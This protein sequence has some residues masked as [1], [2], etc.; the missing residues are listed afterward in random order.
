MS[1]SSNNPNFNAG[2]ASNFLNQQYA[3]QVA[4]SGDPVGKVRYLKT[5]LQLPNISAVQQSRIYQLINEAEHQILNQQQQQRQQQQQQQQQRQPQ[6]QQSQQYMQQQQSRQ[7]QSRQQQSRQQSNNMSQ[8]PMATTS[9]N[10]TQPNIHQM[11]IGMTGSGERNI[12]DHGISTGG[13][14]QMHIPIRGS[15]LSPHQPLE[16][17]NGAPGPASE[18]NMYNQPQQYSNQH[19]NTM[20]VDFS[21]NP[22]HSRGDTGFD[23]IHNGNNNNGYNN[24]YNSG[25]NNGYNSE[26]G[27]SGEGSIVASDNSL[28]RQFATQQQLSTAFH[29]DEQKRSREFEMEQARR[30]Q[31]FQDEQR[32]RRLEYESQLNELEN[33]NINSLRLFG[34]TPQYTL[35]ELKHSYKKKALEVHPDRPGGN[36]D[37]F[38]IVSKCYMELLERLKEKAKQAEIAKM[39]QQSQQPTTQDQRDRLRDMFRER[40]ETILQKG[41]AAASAERPAIGYLDPTNEKG[42]DVK[43]FNKIYE[44]NKLWDPSDEGYG[45]FMKSDETDGPAA[46]KAK[47]IFGNEFN[48]DL[49][50]QTFQEHQKRHQQSV[51]GQ[52]SH[53]LEVKD[54]VQKDSR[55]DLVAIS[56]GVAS[57]DAMSGQRKQSRIN[58]YEGD[59]LVPSTNLLTAYKYNGGIINPLEVQARPEYKNVNELMRDRENISFKL[60]PEDARKQAE[61]LEQ[62]RREEEMRR[63][64]VQEQLEMVDKHHKVTHQRMIGHAP[65]DDLPNYNNRR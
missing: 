15:F 20:P 35:E 34:L 6:Y 2:A 52:G 41:A 27:D 5:L 57:L 37:Q 11:G 47:E 30:A 16:L 9:D 58:L 3:K 25:Y 1:H 26:Y 51:S 22:M 23:P 56:A 8:R 40:N 65:T 28:N 4:S 44:E 49:F 61:Q 7:Q 19:Q 21:M 18:Q 39:Q 55:K 42:F 54:I 36:A 59:N 14:K 62:E 64:R 32:H 31:S 50:N 29:I 17:N 12:M 13:R 33:S 24:D 43:L 10:R 46:P 53:P 38:R 60:S 48:L 63:R 45:D